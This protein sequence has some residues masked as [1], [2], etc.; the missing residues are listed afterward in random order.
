[1]FRISPRN[2][3]FGY[4]LR[5]SF[6]ACNANRT[7]TVTSIN[8]TKL[9]LQFLILEFQME[10]GCKVRPSLPHCHSWGSGRWMCPC[11]AN[12]RQILPTIQRYIPTSVQWND[13]NSSKDWVMGYRLGLSLASGR[14]PSSCSTMWTKTEQQLARR[15]KEQMGEML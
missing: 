11:T 12:S 2:S 1:M 15:G 13:S 6:P 9:W 14:L 5:N 7:S 4:A 3:Q 10:Q 8:F